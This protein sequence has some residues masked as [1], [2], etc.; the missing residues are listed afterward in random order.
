MRAWIISLAI[1]TV[2]IGGCGNPELAVGEFQSALGTGID[3]PFWQDPNFP[4]STQYGNWFDSDIGTWVTGSVV[5]L[6]VDSDYIGDWYE[7]VYCLPP[8]Q[9][10]GGTAQMWSPLFRATVNGVTRE[11]VFN[12][13]ETSFLSGHGWYNGGAAVGLTGGGTCQTGH[14]H[15][16]AGNWISTGPHFCNEVQGQDPWTFWHPVPGY[17]SSCQYSNGTS[18]SGSKACGGGCAGTLCGTHCCGANDWCGTNDRCCSGCA[19]GCPC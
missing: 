8:P 12:H 11:F 14:G 13:L 1:L 5:R 18:G 17:Q 10:P 7:T 19:A 2:S 6:P 16:S 15:D 3:K 9:G 4:G